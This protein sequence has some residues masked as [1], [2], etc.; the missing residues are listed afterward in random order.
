MTGKPVLVVNQ[1]TKVFSSGRRFFFWGEKPA[2]FTAVNQVS[3]KLFR[4]EILGLLG[5]NGA[6]KTTTI[7]MLLSTLKPSEGTI[8]Y[9]GLDLTQNRTEILKIISHASA[10]N[11]LPGNLNIEECLDIF[12]RLYGLNLKERKERIELFLERFDIKDLRRKLVNT[13]SSG[14]MTRLFLAKAFLSFP[15]IVL[16]D[17]PTASLDPDIAKEVREFIVQQ[18]KEFNVSMILTS[19]NMTEVAE[20]CDRVL[21]MNDGKII[22]EDAPHNLA[23]KMGLTEVCLTITEGVEKAESFLKEHHFAY[24]HLEK[25]FSIEVEEAHISKLLSGLSKL[26]VLYSHIEI[27]KPSLEEYFLHITSKRRRP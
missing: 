16:L 11:K 8:H 25:S 24:H 23:S 22:A 10:Y 15:K 20:I 7:Q 4:G 12:G 13:L 19:H 5:P 6:G 1:L 9:F 14:Q 2:P 27:K 17:E 18:Q 26:V 21:V 3:F